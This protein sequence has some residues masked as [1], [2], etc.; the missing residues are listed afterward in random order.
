M[1][2]AFLAAVQCAR[3]RYRGAFEELGELRGQLQGALDGLAAA[4]EALLA[5]FDAW[6]A[7]QPV[8][9]AGDGST[10]QIAAWWASGG[11][12]GGGAAD[13]ADSSCEGEEE[14][15]EPSLAYERLDLARHTATEPD[16]AAFWG[17]R[18]QASRLRET[19]AASP[20][21]TRRGA[22]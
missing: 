9:P 16:S 11:G 22:A 6:L 8:V 5:S 4:K 18:K 15:L 17:A 7:L 3:C 1:C 20:G 13:G 10:Q 12:Q 14:E 2:P 21:A 19:R